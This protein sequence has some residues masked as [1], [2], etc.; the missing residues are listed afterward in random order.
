MLNFQ[1]QT[2]QLLTIQKEVMTKI[3]RIRGIFFHG[4]CLQQQKDRI[5]LKVYSQK[6]IIQFISCNQY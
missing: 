5:F 4:Y 1:I 3:L 2:L 6:Q